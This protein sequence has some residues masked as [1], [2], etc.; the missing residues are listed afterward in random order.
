MAGFVVHE[1][2][3]VSCAHPPGTARPNLPFPRVTVGGRPV[4][5]QAS[6]YTISGCG[7]TGTQPPPC[8]AATYVSAATRVRAG[9]SPVLLQ[10][11]R[12][13]CVPSGGELK[14]D[15]MQTRVRMT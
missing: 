15:A 4:V 9:G 1:G 11:S 8:V 7:R 10:D 3:M 5:T 6:P 12:A 13:I 2:A 14:V